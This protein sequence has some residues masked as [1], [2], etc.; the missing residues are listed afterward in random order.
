[1][2]VFVDTSA[3]YAVL[4]ADDRNHPAAATEWTRLLD[5]GTVLRTHSYVVVETAALIQHRLGMDAAGALHRDVVPA[6]SVR[7][8][9]R[10]L[11]HAATIALLAAGHRHI[12]LVDWTSFELMR[13]EHL[14]KA[15]AFDAD[16][17]GQ[18]FQV[19]PATRGRPRRR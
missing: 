3:L 8:V 16:F 5:E 11:H 10:V 9:D 13:S 6:L 15:F 7:F 18:G 14:G 2:T 17:T 19:V 1:M 12:S 4:D